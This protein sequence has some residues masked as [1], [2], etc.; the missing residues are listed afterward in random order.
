MKKC[1][2]LLILCIFQFMLIAQPPRLRNF[3][4][5]CYVNALIQALYQTHPLNNI[6]LTTEIALELVSIPTR[7]Y[8]DLMLAFIN[9]NQS[10]IDAA[11]FDFYESVKKIFAQPADTSQKVFE[12]N[13]PVQ[14][15]AK[16]SDSNKDLRKALEESKKGQRQEAEQI[17]TLITTIAQAK[18]PNYNKLSAQN[19]EILYSSIKDVLNTFNQDPQQDAH[20]F[21]SYMINEFNKVASEN[22]AK[23]FY[24]TLLD[25][26][27]EPILRLPTFTAKE[28]IVNFLLNRTSQ[29]LLTDINYFKSI[30]DSFSQWLG[31]LNKLAIAPPILIVTLNRMTT[32]RNIVTDEISTIKIAHPI[33][34]PFV[35]DI[36][37][38][39]LQGQSTI[40]EL[41]AVIMHRGTSA[42]SGHYV[43]Y[44]KQN[45]Q[46]YLCNDMQI[47]S[48]TDIQKFVTKIEANGYILFY[49]KIEEPVELATIGMGAFTL[50]QSLRWLQSKLQ[51]LLKSL[52]R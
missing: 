48:V 3:G 22:I 52:T 8:K 13:K 24:Y 40:F 32:G 10:N 9:G 36:T 44:V 35:L 29:S 39:M 34:I 23:T 1:I 4:S 37:K 30:N 42:T 16:K 33:S 49:R 19:K 47:T 21:L 28:T 31:G 11:L 41:Y 2:I 26:Q 43:A 12:K 46:W 25:G 51:D 50:E 20:E 38:H 17:K 5:S 45:N 7:T 14:T 27:T 15:S 6:L 18:N